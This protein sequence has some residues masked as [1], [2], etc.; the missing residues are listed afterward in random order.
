MISRRQFVTGT[1]AT[2]GF[3]GSLSF[4]TS[5]ASSTPDAA[6]ELFQ[7]V[8][9]FPQVLVPG[10]VRIPI[11]LANQAGLLGKTSGID[12]PT[13]LRAQLL[14]AENGEVVIA[15]MVAMKHDANIDPPYWPFRVDIA[16]TGIYTLVIEGGTQDGAGVQIMDPATISIPLIGTPLPGFDTPTISNPRGVNPLCT[17][18]PEP[19]PL[20]DIT[21]N[22]AL[23]RGKPIAY[24]VGTPAHCQTG[25]CAP[26]LEAL[27]SMRELVGDRITMLHTEI[28]SDDTATVVAPAVE[29]LNMTYEPALFITDAKGVLVERFDA[30][31]DAVEITEAFTT[32]GVL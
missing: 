25:T 10:S 24:L 22:E 8:Q 15:D 3:G 1:L 31:F 2:F 17:R 4:L 26:A 13:E 27:L 12:L 29:A 23:K 30:I 21:L 16:E 14:N 20:H 9:R 28:Y 7:V 19:C 32:L 18:T 6:S 5:C 11:S